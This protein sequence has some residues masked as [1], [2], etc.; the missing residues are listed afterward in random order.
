[1]N[2]VWDLLKEGFLYHSVENGSKNLEAGRRGTN[3]LFRVKLI[4]KVT[5][6]FSMPY[7]PDY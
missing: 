7:S 1:M 2:S 5:G 4:N 6:V 3:R